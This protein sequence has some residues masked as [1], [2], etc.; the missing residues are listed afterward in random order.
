MDYVIEK[1][2]ILSQLSIFGAMD[3]KKVIGLIVRI[4][5]TALGYLLNNNK[6]KNYGKN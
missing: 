5:I 6:L 1:C 4:V 2:L 3:K